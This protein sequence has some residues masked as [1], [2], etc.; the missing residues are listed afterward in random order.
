VPVRSENPRDCKFK[1]TK[2]KIHALSPLS[3]HLK[4][5]NNNNIEILGVCTGIH[6]PQIHPIPSPPHHVPCSN[7]LPATL[8]IPNLK[9][10]FHLSFNLPCKLI[11]KCNSLKNETPLPIVKKKV[12]DVMGGEEQWANAQY[13]EGSYSHRIIIPFLPLFY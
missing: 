3:I 12:D 5:N 9:P 6:S 7:P 8:G 11:Y 1:P 13:T 10:S 2:P 4:E